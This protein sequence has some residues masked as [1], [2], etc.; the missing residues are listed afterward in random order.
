MTTPKR[1]WTIKRLAAIAASVVTVSA[2]LL[3]AVWAA[4]AEREGSRQQIEQQ[5]GRIED[6]EARL[7]SV[8]KDL[9]QIATDVRWI[10]A[11]LEQGSGIRE[12][13]GIRGQ[14]SASALSPNPCP[15]TP[16]P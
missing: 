2:A 13:P 10:R 7:R 12:G 6:H 9:G 5:A 16:D 1:T 11:S 3:G 8:E 15:L 14:G 4:S